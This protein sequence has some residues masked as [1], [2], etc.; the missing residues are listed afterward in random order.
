MSTPIL[1]W[2]FKTAFNKAD[3]GLIIEEQT[4]RTV[5]VSYD[6]KDAPLLAAA[7]EMLATL[8]ACLEAMGDYYDAKDAAGD[9][10]ARLHDLITSTIYKA[11]QSA[12]P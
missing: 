6:G 2:Y 10:G 4:G 7:P 12:I 11:T 9:E 5:A 1:P 3:Q 8:Q